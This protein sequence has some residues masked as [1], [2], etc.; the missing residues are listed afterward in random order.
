MSQLS[1]FSVL[2]LI[3]RGQEEKSKFNSKN[4]LSTEK[5]GFFDPAL[6]SGNLYNSYSSVISVFEL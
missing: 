4:L 2:Y 1:I 3:V 5:R 6:T